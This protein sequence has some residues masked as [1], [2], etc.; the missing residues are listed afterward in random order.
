MLADEF[1]GIEDFRETEEF[2]WGCGGRDG[3]GGGDAANAFGGD[4]MG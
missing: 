2:A 1:F 3:W 4:G